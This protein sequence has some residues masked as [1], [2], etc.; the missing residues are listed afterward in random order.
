MCLVCSNET[1][2]K[3][4]VSG[5]YVKKDHLFCDILS[6]SVFKLNEQLTTSSE[7]HFLD[8][9]YYKPSQSVFLC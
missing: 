7:G 6:L 8:F 5:C 3:T 1:C 9:L 4:I 2:D